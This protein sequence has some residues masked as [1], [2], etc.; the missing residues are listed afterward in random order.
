MLARVTANPFLAPSPLPFSFP[1]FDA[2][3]EEH[4]VPAFTVGMAE[5][6]AEVD[7]ITADPGPA[8]FD[9]TL[10][11]L[12]R[13]GAV[14]RRVS[15]VFFA[16]AG[17]C[18][19][20]GIRAIEA[21]IAPRLA[22]HADAIT[23]DPALFVR[24]EAL[25]AARHD[26]GLDAE[27]VRL[28]E[29]RHRD[30]VRAGARLGAAEQERLRAVNAELSVLS[31]EFGARLLAGAN[32]AAVLVRDGAQLD[33]LSPGAIS[34]AARAAT[35]RG[36]DGAY[37]IS[38]VLPTGQPVLASLTD[39]ALRERVHTASVSRGLH[40]DAHDTREIVLRMSALRAERA[41]LL[42][43]PHHASWV[44]ETGTA[45]TVEAID[46]ML[47]KMAPVAAANARAEAAELAAAAGHPIE[48]WD[49]AFH[50]ERVR[51]ERFDLDADALRPYFELERVLHD[52]VFH[53][54]GM[55]YGLRFAERHDLPRYHPEVRIFD[56]FDDDGQLGLF[57]ADLYARDSKRGGAWMN[58]FVTQSRLLDTRPVVLNTLNITR[59]ADGEPTLLTIDNVRTLFH[60][61]GHALHGLFSDVRYPT[62][63]GTSVPRDFV[64]YPSQVNE[65]WLDHPEVLAH[66][67]RHHETG[68][69]LP[70]EMVER[71][72]EA[73]RFG[74][75]FATTEYLAAAL[76]DQAWHRIGRDVEVADVERFE[77]D[78]LDV[79]GIAVSSAPPRY[80]STYFNHVFG[81][82]Y[83]AGYYSYI[84]SEV[85][86]ADTV[87]WFAENGGPCRR[88][89]DAFRRELLSRGGA[90]D[91]MEAYRA[92]RGR[93]PEI[94][95][96][97]ARRGLAG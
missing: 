71:L 87:E 52:G 51:R 42:G 34:A 64:E 1:D 81:G 37:L 31:T 11:A 46:A 57:V 69:P 35:D 55:L 86:D 3:R 15:A 94:A 6:R 58:S 23:L 27:S 16:L 41:A 67:A 21:E 32:D 13:S 90:V 63:S 60:E 74:E 29:R 70:V 14:L 10:V 47:G 91:P 53:A 97:L 28:L 33:G 4:F 62:F 43:Y 54:A 83:S 78:A 36:H 80:R 30:A 22:A 19:T 85:L 68:E 79:A 44:V 59:P 7:A 49:R 9:N 17:S 88:N 95:P 12:E 82:G 5:Q 48:A 26:L 18:S 93:D 89:G 96:L 38:L 72:A 61:F 77:A 92:F 84:W 39:R 45:G 66:Y 8:T 2:I 65:M 56:V 25:F 40:G 24:I 50:A 76:L 20:P 73:R 75:G